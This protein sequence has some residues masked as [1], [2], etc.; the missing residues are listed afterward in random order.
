[1]GAKLPR[2]KQGPGQPPSPFSILPR[3]GEGQLLP[4]A[5]HGDGLLGCTFVLPIKNLSNDGRRPVFSLK[6]P[7]KAY[8]L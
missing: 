8:D 4:V 5:A 3:D 7:D 6:R 1:M 2:K